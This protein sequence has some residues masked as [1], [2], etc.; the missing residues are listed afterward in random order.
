MIHEFELVKDN[1]KEIYNKQ[2]KIKQKISKIENLKGDQMKQVRQSFLNEVF[3]I[4]SK[5]QK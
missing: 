4:I 5:I 1:F 3:S 2:H